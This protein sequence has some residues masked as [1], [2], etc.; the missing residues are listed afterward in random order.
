MKMEDFLKKLQSYSL[1]TLQS[2]ILTRLFSF[3]YEIKI[4][5]NSP[6]TENNNQFSL[7]NLSNLLPM[8]YQPDEFYD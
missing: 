3:A 7:K 2:K 1:F 5:L 8:V 4:N 6:S